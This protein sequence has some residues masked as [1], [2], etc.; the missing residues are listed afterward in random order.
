MRSP[1][2]RSSCRMLCTPHNAFSTTPKC[3]EASRKAYLRAL[4]AARAG[5]LVNK[6]AESLLFR[7]RYAKCDGTQNVTN[8]M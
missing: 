6:K 5:T 4:P 1:R 2:N 3:S 7:V 8:Y